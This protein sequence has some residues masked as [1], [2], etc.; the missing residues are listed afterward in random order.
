[1]NN[2][3]CFKSPTIV[4]ITLTADQNF[5]S[6]DFA[7]SICDQSIKDNTAFE[8]FCEGKGARQLLLMS[9]EEAAGTCSVSEEEDRF[10]L[11][12]EWSAL[13]SGL[14][15][16]LGEESEDFDKDRAEVIS[17]EYDNSK[18]IIKELLLPPKKLPRVLNV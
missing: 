11:F 3:Q 5:V 12:L 10:M 2:R 13:R 15:Q 18:I 17:I 14:A 6:F 1:M 9:F 7:R 16:Y 8:N 4:T